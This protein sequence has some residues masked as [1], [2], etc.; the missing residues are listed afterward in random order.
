[1]T[2]RVLRLLASGDETSHL[3]KLSYDR[4]GGGYDEAWTAHMRDLTAGLIA[5]LEV[6]QGARVLDLACGT[7]FATGLLAAKGEAEVTGVD[8]SGGMLAAAMAS[9]GDR[10]R[11]VEADILEYLRSQPS[12]SHDIVTCCWAL[13]Y[14]RP[15]AVMRQIG[16]VLRPGGRA[17]IIDNSL[18]SLREVL[19][20]SFLAFAEQP[21]K[22]AHLMRFH[23]LP[24]PRSLRLAMR[25]AGLRN[26]HSAA[27]SRTYVVPSG[28]AAIARLRATGA[29]AGFEHAAGDDAGDVF[30]RFAAIME[31]R[32]GTPEG[33]PI[34]HRYIEG[35]GQK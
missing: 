32:Y 35:I 27:G 11:F 14:S 7:G 28:Q 22:L 12:E 29:A 25:M 30:S 19:F 24:G 33:I 23:F 5:R 9:Y 34:V 20:S 15:F 3:V 8:E 2:M 26:I 21:E 16:R 1:M 10:C 6:P 31:E 18:F 4:I 17:A 13:G